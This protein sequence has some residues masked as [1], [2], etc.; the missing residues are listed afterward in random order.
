MTHVP[1]PFDSSCI[2]TSTF[3]LILTNHYRKN[4][5][6]LATAVL[7]HASVTENPAKTSQT[8]MVDLNKIAEMIEGFSGVD[9]SSVANTALS[10]V[11]HGHIQ[12]YPS[13]EI[14]LKHT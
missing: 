13:P 7:Y 2:S 8:K 5:K 14:A 11:L 4:P 1:E 10:L 9:V 3:L 6:A 12:K